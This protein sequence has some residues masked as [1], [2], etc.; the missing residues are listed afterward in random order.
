MEIVHRIVE[1]VLPAA[2]PGRLSM[3]SSKEIETGIDVCAFALC[4]YLAAVRDPFRRDL[5]TKNF[6]DFS[7]LCAVEAAGTSIAEGI[8]IID[9][10]IRGVERLGIEN[11]KGLASAIRDG[12]ASTAVK[13][14]R[15]RRV[16]LRSRGKQAAQQKEVNPTTNETQSRKL[17][18]LAIWPFIRKGLAKRVARLLSDIDGETTPGNISTTSDEIIEDLARASHL[19]L[20]WFLGSHGDMSKA[21][22]IALRWAEGV[23]RVVGF[24]CAI[25]RAEQTGVTVRQALGKMDVSAKCEIEIGGETCICWLDENGNTRISGPKEVQPEMEQAARAHDFLQNISE[26]IGTDVNRVD[27]DVLDGILRCHHQE[28]AE[29]VADGIDCDV[30]EDEFQIFK[31]SYYDVTSKIAIEAAGGNADRAKKL[32]PAIQRSV[33]IRLHM[34]EAKMEKRRR[35]RLN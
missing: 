17:P 32:K 8:S 3:V 2:L 13:R 15:N 10:L 23:P 28:L 26:V 33:L 34:M 18:P 21:D 7:L 4:W 11:V 35:I 5:L 20:C 6:S 30:S 12:H 19:A 22:R 1:K 25:A 29:L 14:P 9:A 16:R 24:T 27:P 31:Q